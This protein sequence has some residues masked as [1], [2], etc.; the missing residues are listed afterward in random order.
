MAGRC[1]SSPLPAAQRARVRARSDRDRLQTADA[2]VVT[3]RYAR[4]MNP[5]F[6]QD[7]PPAPDLYAVDR[8]LHAELARRLPPEIAKKAAPRFEAMGRATANE[9][10]KLMVECEANEPV[11]VPYDP[12][13]RRVDEIRM[14]PAW[15]A[16]KKFSAENGIVAAGYDESY[17]EH[18]RV[19]QAVLLHLFSASSAIYSCPLA[20]TDAAARVL[21][22]IGTPE[23]R[24]RLVPRLLSTDARTFITSGQW[25]TERTGG[26]DVG[27]TS[28][29]ARALPDGDGRRYSLH[30]VKW[31]TSAVTSEMALALARVENERGEVVL[32]SKGLTLFAVDVVRDPGA[33]VR[34][35]LVNRLKDKLG[36]RALPTA[37]L[38]LQGVEAV[39]IGDV[40]RGVASIAGMLNVTRFYNSVASSS[41]MHKAHALA[42]AYAWKRVA[43]S[44]PIASHPL[45]AATL[46]EMEAD[47]AAGLAIVMEVASLLG[48]LEHGVADDEEKRRLRA[49]VPLTKLTTGKQT[50]AVTSEAI[51]SFGGAGYIEDTGL[52][53]L[54]RDSQ[55][56]PIWEG[57]TNVLSLDLL[58]AEAKDRAYSAVLTDL[59]ARTEKLPSSLPKAGVDLLK[60]TCQALTARVATLVEKGELEH[61][62]RRVALTTGLCYESMLLG[63]TAAHAGTPDAAARFER[64][65]RARLSGP[66]G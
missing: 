46:D 60:A 65:T 20:M 30:G 10:P 38:T 39:R 3:V 11:H 51:E 43:F 57:T 32:G 24:D 31:F 14:S 9:L 44:A 55:V 36:T 19:V 21:L 26:S 5:S 64:F 66:L 40:G 16:L 22:D 34:G 56:L 28:T 50:V 58:R 18:R 7:F 61:G 41:T 63:E 17:G 53:T 27:G 45:H 25:M 52:P 2:D 6:Y 8:A 37:E 1:A 54:L 42:R 33:G 49:L 35:I 12:W 48:K 15:D 23:L 62:A 47:A 13:G 4:R 29:I 59:L